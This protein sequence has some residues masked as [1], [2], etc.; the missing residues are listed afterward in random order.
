M[1]ICRERSMIGHNLADN[2]RVLSH[3]HDPHGTYK[4]V[5]LHFITSCYQYLTPL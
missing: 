4:A 2:V 5:G 3:K 1:K